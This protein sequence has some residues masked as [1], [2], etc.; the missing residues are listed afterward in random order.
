MEAI[1]F[2]SQL[3]ELFTFAGSLDLMHISDFM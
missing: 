2:S 3:I 1:S